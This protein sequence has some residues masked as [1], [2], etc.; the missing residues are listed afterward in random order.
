MNIEDLLCLDINFKGQSYKIN[1]FK[2]IKLREYYPFYS[3]DLLSS[4]FV[5]YIV[6]K[7][8]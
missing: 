3:D 1:T 6:M 8:K 2:A 7:P 5:I 4:V